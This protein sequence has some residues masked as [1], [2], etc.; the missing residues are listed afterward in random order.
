ML[1]AL[2][3]NTPKNEREVRVFFFGIFTAIVFAMMLY[4]VSLAINGLWSDFVF[5]AAALIVFTVLSMLVYKL[6][7]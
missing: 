2:K 7:K 6:K 1:Q 3:D 5:M 4:M